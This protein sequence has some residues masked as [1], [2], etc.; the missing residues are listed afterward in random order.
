MVFC[1]TVGAL[2][3]GLFEIWRFS[4]QR[5]YSGFK[6]IHRYF[7]LHLGTYMVVTHTLL[8]NLTLICR[9]CWVVLF[10][11]CIKHMNGFHSF[12]VNCDGCHMWDRKCS[13]FPEH[14]ISHPLG[15]S[16]YRQSWDNVYGLMP[17]LFAWVNLTALSRTYFITIITFR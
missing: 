13:L 17:G 7:R 15:S 16:W 8:T 10:T 14:L 2:C 11:N 4:V 6:V 9:I 12:Q 3:L 5:I 1:F